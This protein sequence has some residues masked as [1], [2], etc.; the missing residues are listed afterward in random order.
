MQYIYEV[1]LSHSPG[2]FSETLLGPQQSTELRSKTLASLA[3]KECCF[4]YS[5]LKIDTLKRS[6]HSRMYNALRSSLIQE[7]AAVYHV[8]TDASE[9]Q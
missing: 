9:H 2:C 5:L 4:W 6:L 7:T 3:R 8:A 1:W